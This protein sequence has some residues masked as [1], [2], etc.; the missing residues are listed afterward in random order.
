MFLKQ[1][2]KF[3]AKSVRAKQF[4]VSLPNECSFCSANYLL[5]LILG[6]FSDGNVIGVARQSSSLLQSSKKIELLSAMSAFYK[7]LHCLCVLADH[8]LGKF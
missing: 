5:L 2:H 7:C 6:G 3:L 1:R 4:G 8:V